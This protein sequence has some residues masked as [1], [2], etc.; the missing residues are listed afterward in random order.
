MHHDIKAIHDTYYEFPSTA[1]AKM[2]KM[3]ELC[4]GV[5]YEARQFYRPSVRKECSVLEIGLVIT[6]DMSKC[7]L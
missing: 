5:R 1:F 6:D 7:K 4:F 2:F 3:K